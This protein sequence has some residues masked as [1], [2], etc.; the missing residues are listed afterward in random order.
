MTKYDVFYRLGITPWERY[1]SASAVSVAAM[2]DREREERPG[3]PGRALDLGCGR[4]RYTPE[5][6]T[7]GWQASGVDVVPRAI[8]AARRGSR[9][10]PL[11]TRRC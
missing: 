2:L 10:S 7:R 4:G 6:A 5:L 1:A 11:R 9:A 3:G 8:E